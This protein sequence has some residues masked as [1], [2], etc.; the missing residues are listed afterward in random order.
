MTHNLGLQ[1]KWIHSSGLPR[2][3]SHQTQFD[4]AED[5]GV[6]MGVG[7]QGWMRVGG[8]NVD[9]RINW[10]DEAPR[11]R[12]RFVTVRVDRDGNELPVN[13]EVR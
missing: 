7:E 12:I 8:I 1:G 9:G 2:R 13:E 11:Q 10:L 6:N 5:L 4:S 3:A